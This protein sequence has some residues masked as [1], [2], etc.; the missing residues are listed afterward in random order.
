MKDDFRIFLSGKMTGLNKLDMNS[1]RS[2]FQKLVDDDWFGYTRTPHVINPCEYFGNLD[3]SPTWIEHKEYIRWELRQARDCDLLVAGIS[4][5][6]DSIGTACEITTAYEAGKPILLYNQYELLH[7][8]IH[9]FV[10]EMSDRC[11]EK[12]EDL[13][14]YIREV[15]LI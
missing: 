5:N 10:W 15:Y 2:E 4:R 13:A 14:D 7:S 6:Q 11:F 3:D 8:D 9:P 12:L 1:W